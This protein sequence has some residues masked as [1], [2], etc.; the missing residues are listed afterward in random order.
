VYLRMSRE[1]YRRLCE[2]VA[3][4]DRAVAE[5]RTL[6]AE[7]KVSQAQEDAAGGDGEMI[8]L[9]AWNVEE[10]LDADFGN[11]LLGSP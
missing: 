5:L 2:R 10:L 11:D 4:Y 9:C 6:V 7:W 3:A 1:E 8:G